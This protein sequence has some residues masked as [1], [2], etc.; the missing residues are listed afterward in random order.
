MPKQTQ[1]L[2]W[3]RA[4]RDGDLSSNCSWQAAGSSE[5]GAEGYVIEEKQTIDV[6]G[7]WL[8]PNGF[9]IYAHTLFRKGLSVV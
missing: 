3:S 5:E 9:I 1:C 7:F 8:L 4:L 6:R 2:L